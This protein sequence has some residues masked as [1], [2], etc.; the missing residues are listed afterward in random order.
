[1]QPSQIGF[2]IRRLKM[3]K[4]FAK[5]IFNLKYPRRDLRPHVLK[6]GQGICKKNKKSLNCFVSWKDTK[7]TKIHAKKYL[8]FIELNK[9]VQFWFFDHNSQDRWIREHFQRHPI[10]RIYQRVRFPALKSDIFRYCLLHE[11]GGIYTGINS[12]FDR[13]LSGFFSES[14]EFYISFENNQ[15]PIEFGNFLKI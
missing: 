7:L 12:L 3:L 9:D 11:Y 13:S 8:N 15:F 14:D 2:C 4:Y 10:Y 1:M 6:F 5:G